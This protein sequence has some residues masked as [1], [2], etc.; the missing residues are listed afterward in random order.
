MLNFSLQ[1]FSDALGGTRDSAYH[2][3]SVDCFAFVLL[4]RALTCLAL[5]TCCFQGGLLVR[6]GDEIL[7]YTIATRVESLRTS[8]MAPLSA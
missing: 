3:C 4:L 5:A 8:M 7:D 6:M 2:A 1:I